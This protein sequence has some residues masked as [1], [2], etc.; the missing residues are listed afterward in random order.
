MQLQ[1]RPITQLLRVGLLAA[2]MAV[3]ALPADRAEGGPNLADTVLPLRDA[4]QGMTGDELFARLLEHNRLRDAH[5]HQYSAVRSYEVKDSEGRLRAQ[6]TVVLQYMAPETKSFKT[7]SEKGSWIIRNLV[8]K[9]LMESEVEA[10]AGQQHR[11]SSIKPVNYTFTLIG[12][13]DVG[14]YRCLVVDAVPKRRDKYLFEGRVWID[15]E[16]F[17]VVRIAGQPA[18]KLSFWI[19][20]VNFVR[21]YQRI[22]EFWLP[23]KDE[24]FVDVK[25]YGKKVFAIDH[26]DY[27]INGSDASDEQTEEGVAALRHQ[28]QDASPVPLTRE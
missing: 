3:A 4:F 19:T 24:T 1:L 16:D 23:S 18:K 13:Q 17:G 7:T 10:S 6:E 12:E 26:R 14:P 15:A 25:L 2:M 11:D 22:G 9:R 27:A 8:F 5:L 20:R 28:G 21:Q